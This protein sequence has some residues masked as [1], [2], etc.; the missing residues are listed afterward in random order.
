MPSSLPGDGAYGRGCVDFTPDVDPMVRLLR[1]PTGTGCAGLG[2]QC[3]VDELSWSES[4]RDLKVLVVIG[5]G[6][7]EDDPIDPDSARSLAAS[8]GISIVPVYCG[9]PTD[10]WERRTWGRLLDDEDGASMLPGSGTEMEQLLRTLARRRGFVD[11]TAAR[12]QA[13]CSH[14]VGSST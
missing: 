7:F 4:D 13:S 9:D 5:D 2:I 12:G 6:D 8:R 3:A 1:Q 11:A 14:S 10:T